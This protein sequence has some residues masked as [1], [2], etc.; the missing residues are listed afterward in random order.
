MYLLFILLSLISYYTFLL[1]FQIN[2]QREDT[3]VLFGDRD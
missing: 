3:S 1:L 2:T